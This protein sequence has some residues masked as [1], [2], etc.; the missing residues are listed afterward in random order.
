MN[1][2]LDIFNLVTFKFV[3]ENVFKLKVLHPHCVYSI[4]RIM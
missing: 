3:E 4:T 1:D 2:K